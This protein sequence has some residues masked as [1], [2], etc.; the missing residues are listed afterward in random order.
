MKTINEVINYS[1]NYDRNINPYQINHHSHYPQNW[2]YG[3]HLPSYQ[4]QQINYDDYYR[5]FTPLTFVLVHGSWVGPSFWHGI[6]AELQKM[7][8]KVHTPQ[9][10]GHGTDNNKNVTHA[11]I[12]QSVVD[13][14]R[15]KNLKNIILVG[16]SFGGSVIQKV[17]E[18]VPERIR[19]LVFW[20][21]FVINDGESL[22]DQF[23]PKVRDFILGLAEQSADNTIKLPFPFF[24]ETFVNLAD[25]QTASQIYN[26][27]I[28][29]PGAPLV[30]KLDLKNFFQLTTPRSYINLQ[31]D[32]AVPPGENSGWFPHLASRLGVYRL[33]QGH[34][35]HMTTAKINPRMVA[36]LI[37]NAGRD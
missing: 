9:L 22:A 1:F 35:D 34:G 8:H 3:Y 30:E 27:T 29:E 28:P 23:P 33:I 21:A 2:Y 6:A 25:L 12:T 37:V 13:Y 15:S 17:A 11:M 26:S 20:N 24:R 14:I 16:H 10:A 7:G 5:Q 36:Q 18:Q 4:N 19:R 32:T 31:E